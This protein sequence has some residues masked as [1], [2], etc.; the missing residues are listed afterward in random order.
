MLS[1]SISYLHVKLIAVFFLAVF[2]LVNT[3]GVKMAGR[4]QV[5]MVMA[6]LVLLILYVVFGLPGVKIERYVPVLPANLGILFSTAG[7]V[8]ISYGGLTKVASVAEEV[9]DPGK[10]LP[11]ALISSWLVTTLL[12]GL[13]I[14]VTV[15]LLPPDVMASSA[16][17]I[18]HAAEVSMGTVG[19]IALSVAGVLAVLT[20][21]NAGIL[22]AS[23]SPMAMARDNLLPRL[24]LRI[25]SRFGTP[26]TSILF[27]GL[28]MFVVIAFLD[29]EHLIKVASTLK[30]ALFV[31]V[32]VCVIVMRESKMANYRPNFRAPGYPW[33]QIVGIVGPLFL[34]VQFG[35]FPL[36][37]TA[38]FG[39]GALAWYFVYARPRTARESALVYMVERLVSRRISK[40][41]L[42]KELKDIIQERDEIVEDRFDHLIRD[43]AILD[44]GD[45]I[46][47]D[48]FF[49]QVADV[50]AARTDVQQ[51]IIYERLW[52]R[53]RE[54]STV[55]G[56]NLA[57]PHVILPGE[58][59]FDIVLARCPEGIVF[60]S[61]SAP[62]NTV[63]VLAGTK[64][65]RNFHLK[66]LAAIAKI[67]QESG[68]DKSWLTAPR[69]EDLR[70]VILLAE[71]KRFGQAGPG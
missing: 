15:G 38:L 55:V 59:T 39:L 29:L 54:S 52:E 26:H 66:A 14:S 41:L 21:A 35:L 42:R 31:L 69:T 37:V 23:R 17:P 22:A 44:L 46:T 60:D 40:G 32:N 57:V 25:N 58:R 11:L 13:V 6:L 18:S 9:R 12:Y 71:R 24:F 65:E 45:R 50:L 34:L 63:F 64:D 8:F 10:T 19:L 20:T 4:A 16:T 53:E 27:T 36:L 68:F 67:V 7:F 28:F 33:V 61:E 51:T 49:R 48:E 47:L 56:P 2:V 1:P 62:V 70:D 5:T 30:V 43:C 3:T